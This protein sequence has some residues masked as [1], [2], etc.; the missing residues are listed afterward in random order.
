MALMGCIGSRAREALLLAAEEAV[1]ESAASRL[2]ALLV[3]PGPGGADGLS[4]SELGQR[5]LLH[6]A[7]WLGH[8][9]CVR[10]L[11]EHGA[12]VDEP[13]RKNGCTPLHLA[14][15]C[16][17]DDTDPA[18]TIRA[19]TDAGADINNPGSTKC[20]RHPIDHAVQHQ[21]LDSVRV[22]LSHGSQVI[23]SR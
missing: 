23:N 20:G 8:T 2:E 22:L 16:T 4:A 15:F 3:A 18:R 9:A 5:H 1:K 19:L 10:L 14:H 7:A 21:R 12:P 6:Q 17:I 13:H 11:L